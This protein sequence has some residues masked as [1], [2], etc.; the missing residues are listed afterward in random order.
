M[1]L[2]LIIDAQIGLFHE[3]D[4]NN[5]SYELRHINHFGGVDFEYGICNYDLETNG[6][7]HQLAKR[8][9]EHLPSNSVKMIVG[10]DNIDL[11]GLTDEAF[12]ALTESPND[13]HLMGHI[14]AYNN[15]LKKGLRPLLVW[16]YLKEEFFGRID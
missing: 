11:E 1:Y 8:I 6:L 5:G 10:D 16:E 14:R 2:D 4:D 13:K 15:C 12:D 7:M 9:E 3:Y